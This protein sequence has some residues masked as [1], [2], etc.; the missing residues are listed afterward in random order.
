MTQETAKLA[1]TM[2]VVDAVVEEL[3]RQG[4]TEAMADL[5]FNPW[6]LA[7]AVIKAADG[8]VTDLSSRRDR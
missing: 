7:E 4:I 6:A 1:R 2:K 5:G 3:D 8:E